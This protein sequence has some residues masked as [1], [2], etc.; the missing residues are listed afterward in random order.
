MHAPPIKTR[1]V[2]QLI[3][4][5]PEDLIADQIAVKKRWSYFECSCKWKGRGKLISVWRQPAEKQADLTVDLSGFFSS[6]VF[7]FPVYYTVKVCTFYLFQ[8]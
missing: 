3:R 7:Q 6:A 4:K 1:T 2:D 5:K 8:I